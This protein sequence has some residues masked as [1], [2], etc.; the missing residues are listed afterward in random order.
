MLTT[1]VTA[2][3]RMLPVLANTTVAVGHV[4]TQLPGLLLV[5][6]HDYYLH[7][8]VRYPRSLNI[9]SAIGEDMTNNISRRSLQAVLWIRIRKNPNILTGS[10]SEKKFD[11]CK[12]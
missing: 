7:L 3:A 11:C 6:R 9:H 12:I 10:E 2:T 1:G 5:G 8:K 4:A